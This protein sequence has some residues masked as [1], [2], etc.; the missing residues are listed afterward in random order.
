MGD[1]ENRVIPGLANED[2]PHLYCRYVDD[3]FIVVPHVD[4]A[5]TLKE[6]LISES[7]LQFT[8][9]I[10]KHKKL[11]FLDVSIV[12]ENNSFVTS[13]YS[14]P[15]SSDECLNYRSIAPERYKTGVIKTILHRAHKTTSSP[16]LFDL[17]VNRIRQILTDNDYP[18]SIIDGEVAKF[19]S[20]IATVTA[21]VEPQQCVKLY[22]RNQMTSQY[23]QDERNLRSVIDQYVTPE[24]DKTLKLFIY[25]KNRKVSNMFV[26]NKTV[27]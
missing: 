11:N 26:K 24:Q 8:V 1:I 18:S 15:T 14:K 19:R 3:I 20:R 4:V 12:S 2:R 17:E 16:T 27:Y 22:Y 6:K 21:I 9:E 7:V 23:K 13:V 5:Y 25:Y 10:E